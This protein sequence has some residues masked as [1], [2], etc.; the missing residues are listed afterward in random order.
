[1]YFCPLAAKVAM[2]LVGQRIRPAPK[3]NLAQSGEFFGRVHIFPV[4]FCGLHKIKGIGVCDQFAVEIFE[5]DIEA[6]VE[7]FIKLSFGFRL[8]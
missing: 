4:G 6:A 7:N 5:V 3:A 2:N 1:M 8:Q